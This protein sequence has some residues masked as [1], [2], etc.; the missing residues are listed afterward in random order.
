MC[1][2]CAQREINCLL[3]KASLGIQ[4]NES[5]FVRS[6]SILNPTI[7]WLHG[8]FFFISTSLFVGQI[9]LKLSVITVRKRSCRKV[10]F[11][12]LLVILFTGSVYPSM[13]WGRHTPLGQT[14]PPWPDTPVWAYTP[15]EQT[16][17]SGQTTPGR[18]LPGQTSPLPSA[19]WDTHPPAQCMLGYNPP[20]PAATAADGTHPTG[21]HSCLLLCSTQ[22]LCGQTKSICPHLNE[23]LK[24]STI[25]EGGNDCCI[26]LAVKKHQ[27]TSVHTACTC[28]CLLFKP[29]NT[30]QSIH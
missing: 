18:H 24:L 28:E 19:C 25:P 14:H 21:I 22:F 16:P 30:S 29:V 11:L 9:P 2:N 20:S 13:H 1:F 7:V 5:H 17:P 23:C 27:R 3:K 4:Q 10:M 12:H 15:P 6:F 26:R 8:M